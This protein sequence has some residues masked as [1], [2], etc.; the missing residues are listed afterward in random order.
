MNDDLRA[1]GPKDPGNEADGH[2]S[3]LEAIPAVGDTAV[4]EPA[5]APYVES[6]L[7]DARSAYVGIHYERF[8]DL[9]ARCD[10]S[11]GVRLS[12][13]LAPFLFG[14]LWFLYRKMYLEGFLLLLVS[15][16]LSAYTTISR[17]VGPEAFSSPVTT[18]QFS[19]TV[20]AGLFGK[21]LYWKATDRRIKKAMG[22]FP[23]EPQRALAWLYS[24]GG[25]NIPIV[26]LM[27][28]FII[29]CYVMMLVVAVNMI[30]SG[31]V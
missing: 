24:R 7:D 25:V 15:L 10:A 13:G 22:L 20:L 29:A 8:E 19:L 9:F 11:N 27:I 23:R 14:S 26:V 3:S 2:N 18:L 6:T 31:A 1:N 4:R 17:L 30:R 16:P 21:A 28:G 5:A 12:F